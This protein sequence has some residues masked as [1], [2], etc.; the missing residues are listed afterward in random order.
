[1]QAGAAPTGGGGPVLSARKPRGPG[2]LRKSCDTEIDKRAG[3]AK[4]GGPVN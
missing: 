2:C 4:A 3:P 1:M